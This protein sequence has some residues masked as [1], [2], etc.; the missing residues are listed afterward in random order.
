M[1][2]RLA[3]WVRRHPL[4]LA[5]GLGFVASSA[6]AEGYDVSAFSTALTTLTGDLSAL[7]A[8]MAPAIVTI[9][10]ITL[11]IVAINWLVRKV[12]GA[13]GRG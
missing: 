12:R 9:A 13:I 2:T 5:L 10:G 8:V 11:I 4:A 1:V 7:V 3:R 6:R